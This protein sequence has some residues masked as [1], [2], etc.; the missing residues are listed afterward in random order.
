M[1]RYG[2]NVADVRELVETAIGGATATEIL[3][4]RPLASVVID[5]ITTSTL[6]T[7][8][9]LPTLYELIEAWS[10]APREGLRAG[11]GLS[12]G[13]GRAGAAPSSRSPEP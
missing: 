2:L 9:V 3:E 1:A 8:I 11:C 4:Q 5:G 13:A 7:L 12:L 10:A 6:L